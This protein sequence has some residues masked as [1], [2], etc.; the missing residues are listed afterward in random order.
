MSG[1]IEGGIVMGTGNALTEHYIEEGGVPWTQHLGQYKMP[2]TLLQMENGIGSR[3][4]S[5]RGQGRGRSAPSP[6]SRAASPTPY[7]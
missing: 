4:R 1:Q 2:G 3:G 6:R 7:L 5:I